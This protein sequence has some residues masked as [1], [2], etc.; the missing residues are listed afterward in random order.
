MRGKTKDRVKINYIINKLNIGE[1]MQSLVSEKIIK[2]TVEK[3]TWERI[4]LYLDVKVEYLKDMDKEQ[5]LEFYAVNGLHQAKVFFRYEK[6]PN[7][8]YRLKCNVTNN[9]ENRCI[10]IG[11]YR[12]FVCQGDNKL[13]ECETG[14]DIIQNIS[15]YSRNFLYG[16]K[17]K[18]YT[19]TFYVEEGEDTLPFRFYVL[20]SAR[21][22]MSFPKNKKLHP[23]KDVYKKF[24]SSREFLRNLYKFYANAD[25]KKKH[26]K[27]RVLFMTEQ[28]D[29]IA[30]NLLAVSEQ[31][32]K[33]GLEQQF[34]IKYS[35]R[36]AA[37]GPQSHKSWMDLMKKLA[38]SDLIFLD[39]HAP[40]LDWLRLR[41]RTEVVQLWHAGAGFKSSG[42]SRWGHIGCPAPV[43]CHRQYKYGIAGSRQIAHFF[44]EVWG[45]N[46]E[47]VLPTGM[48]RMDEYLDPDYHARKKKELYEQY[49]M[50]K[51]KKVILFAPTYRGKNKKEAYYPYDLIDFQAWYDQCGEESVVLF[52][53][54][55]W[56]SE[57]VPIEEKYQD[58]FIDVGLYPN[59][60]DL[61]YIT[62]LLITDYSSSIFEYSLMK[63][64]MLFFA[65]DKIQYSFSRGFHRPYEESAPGKVVYTF[66]ELLQAIRDKDFHFE[67]VQEYVDKHFDYIDSHASDR[68]I[69]WIVMGNIPED[70]QAGM[71]ENDIRNE[72]MN[73]LDFTPELIGEAVEEDEGD[74][75]DEEEEEKPLTAEED[76]AN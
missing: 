57:P 47:Q 49:P 24:K 67:K 56:V 30:S 75:D 66:E 40:V 59:I 12:I 31:M 51:G 48:P 5:P 14:L 33:R 18:V 45:I 71:D 64:P 17:K 21:N 76:G 8:V 44:S 38:E 46:D 41:E 1:E 27:K 72:R 68:V 13:A 69:D 19:V 35:A 23:V 2:A 52:K 10:P 43:S 37:A 60:N 29:V 70:L 32:K 54:H 74:E 16:G 25:E 15:N 7:D 65:F 3:I 55:P 53:M 36:A 73:S 20:S 50:C 6:L 11:T 34:E 26:P 62:D 39:D 4:F 63:K 9:G 22:G 42:Y 61:F 58:R 28:N